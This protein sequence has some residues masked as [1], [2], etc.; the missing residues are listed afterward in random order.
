MIPKKIVLNVS[1]DSTSWQ[2]TVAK[3]FPFLLSHLAPYS[4][5]CASEKR[6]RCPLRLPERASV[7]SSCQKATR[8][9]HISHSGV[10]NESNGDKRVE[11]MLGV[12][13][14]VCHSALHWWAQEPNKSWEN[15]RALMS[16]CR[17]LAVLLLEHH[18]WSQV[19]FFFKRD[20]KYFSPKTLLLLVILLSLSG[21]N[22]SDF[23]FLT[24]SDFSARKQFQS[25]WVMSS[26]P[27]D[28]QVLLLGNKQTMTDTMWP[29]SG[30]QPGDVSPW[31][32]AWYES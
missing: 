12:I 5:E 31:E 2:S 30:F 24:R 14:V 9:R 8:E 29:C 27:W 23:L 32:I 19:D 18:T 26:C 11:D 17:E 4:L 21:F 28:T 22:T 25:L 20:G 13:T 16:S 1:S 6:K 7:M 3:S 10:P 15:H